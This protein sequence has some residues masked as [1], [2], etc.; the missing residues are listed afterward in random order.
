MPFIVS[1][2]LYLPSFLKCQTD[3]PCTCSVFFP[4]CMHIFDTTSVIGHLL[5]LVMRGTSKTPHRGLR[6]IRAV[7]S[8][9]KSAPFQEG[10]PNVYN[11]LIGCGLPSTRSFNLVPL[12][13]RSFGRQGA[14]RKNRRSVGDHRRWKAGYRPERHGYGGRCCL[15]TG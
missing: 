6:F 15:R 4:A 13:C 3:T 9:P 1:V 5:L 8:L 10:K 12:S 7:F 11:A 14:R 2:R